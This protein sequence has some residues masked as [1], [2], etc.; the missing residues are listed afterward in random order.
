MLNRIMLYL[1]CISLAFLPCSITFAD[2]TP[3]QTIVKVN[4]ILIYMTP[5]NQLVAVAKKMN[6][7]VSKKIAIDGS[8][9]FTIAD[10]KLAAELSNLYN[11]AITADS[12]N[13]LVLQENTN[14]DDN[15]L[16]VIQVHKSRFMI[17]GVRF[18]KKRWR[19]DL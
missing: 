3:E 16:E 11:S 15:I 8:V 13:D 4:G 2:T 9:E 7:A 17:T 6:V 10:S 1:A 18:L 19:Y 5:A 14:N 12:Q